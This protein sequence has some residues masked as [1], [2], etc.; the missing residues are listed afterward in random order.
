M[1][2]RIK[3]VVST[4]LA[5][6][7][8][9]LPADPAIE[10]VESWDSFRHIEIILAVEGELGVKI[11]TDMMLEL[12]SVDRIARFLEAQQPDTAG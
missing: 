12:T 10:N 11:P 2:E 1:R 4:I 3:D 6:P 5:I 7:I 9:E 8:S